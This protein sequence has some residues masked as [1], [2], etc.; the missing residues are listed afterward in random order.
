MSINQRKPK[1]HG[2]GGG[3]IDPLECGSVILWKTIDSGWGSDC[4]S[5][6]INLSDCNRHVSWHIEADQTGLDKLDLAISILQQARKAT[7]KVI[8]LKEK[9]IAK[10]KALNKARLEKEKALKRKQSKS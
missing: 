1:L 10:E 7:E 6:T 3:Y 4:F 5:T 9:Q 8:P 2:Q